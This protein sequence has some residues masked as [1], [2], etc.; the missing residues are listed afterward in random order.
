MLR[1]RIT[2]GTFNRVEMVKSI[3]KCHHVDQEGAQNREWCV[4][5][6]KGQRQRLLG[7]CS[8]DLSATCLSLGGHHL[9]FF[10]FFSVR[11]HIF[12]SVLCGNFTRVC[13][14]EAAFKVN[15]L[16]PFLVSLRHEWLECLRIKVPN[17]NNQ[18]P[19]EKDSV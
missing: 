11:N 4:P 15:C 17:S 14:G 3:F 5:G 8:T 19:L 13:K 12:L 9:Y 16:P 6:R 18:I 10:H 2:E 7:F 1:E